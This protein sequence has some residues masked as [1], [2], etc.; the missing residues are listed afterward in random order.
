MLKD[1]FEKFNDLVYSSNRSL[2]AQVG[3]VESSTLYSSL[4]SLQRARQHR[5]TFPYQDTTHQV[6]FQKVDFSV[7][8]SCN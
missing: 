3:P 1:L 7:C 2:L 8:V 5:R 6:S 4:R